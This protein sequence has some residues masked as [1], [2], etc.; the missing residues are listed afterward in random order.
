MNVL[1]CRSETLKNLKEISY[2]KEENKSLSDTV[3]K[4]MWEIQE[5]RVKQ[6]SISRIAGEI[7]PWNRKEKLKQ[8]RAIRN[9]F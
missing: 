6:M 2:L 4:L 7:Y 9:S 1:K 8:I 5:Y 3:K